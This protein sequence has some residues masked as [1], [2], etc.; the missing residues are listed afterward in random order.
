MILIAQDEPESIKTFLSDIGEVAALEDEDD[1][2]IIGKNL[3]FGS[4]RKTVSNLLSSFASGQLYDQAL[5]LQ[6]K[7]DV[8]SIIVEGPFSPDPEG[9]LKTYGFATQWNYSSVQGLLFS[10]LLHGLVP[11]WTSSEW[12]TAL[13]LRTIHD[14]LVNEGKRLQFRLP[15]IKSFRK[16][17]AAQQV[18][19]SFP[20]LNLTLARRIQKQH[21]TLKDFF[22]DLIFKNGAITSQIRGIGGGKT[23][24]WCEVL[25]LEEGNGD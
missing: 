20:G 22:L 12:A 11:I 8:V 18:L 4:Q 24:T 14:Q 13:T 6:G 9:K 16:I 5:R 3:S 2:V 7:Y 1:Y 10:L 19:C 17:S 15:K 23:A 25:F 21:R